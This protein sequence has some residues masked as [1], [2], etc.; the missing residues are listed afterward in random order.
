MATEIERKFL[1]AGDFKSEA[2]DHKVIKQGY[3]IP[4]AEGRSVRI[5]RKGNK[6][7]ITIKGPTSE[8]GLSRYEWEKE[9]ALEEAEELLKLCSS[10]YVDK[11]RYLVKAGKHTFEVDEFCGLNKGLVVAEIELGSEDEEFIR[12]SWLG[13]EVTGDERYYNSSLAR[14]PYSEWKDRQ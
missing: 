5:R 1:I 3:I 12:P 10:N 13:K 7:F 6:G 2:F 9:I 14:Y 8:N 11:V 4:E